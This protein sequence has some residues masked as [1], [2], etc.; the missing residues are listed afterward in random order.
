MKKIYFLLL[1]ISSLFYSCAA[2]KFAL[3]TNEND[4]LSRCKR[5]RLVE[6][7][8]SSSVYTVGYSEYQNQLFYYFNNGILTRIDVGVLQPNIRIDQ[9]IRRN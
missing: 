6:S 7:Q 1:I 2:P 5:A 4:F 9:T 8:N 3:G